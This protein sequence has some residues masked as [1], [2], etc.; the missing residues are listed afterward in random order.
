MKNFTTNASNRFCIAVVILSAAVC[1]AGAAV[2]GSETFK[3]K[4]AGCHG[5]DGGGKTALGTKLKLRDLRSADVQ[6]QSDSELQSVIEKGKA[7]MPAFGKTLG[8]PAVQ[9]LVAYMRTIAAK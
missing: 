4:C 1:S 5:A 8:A 9:E 7:P 2:A 6:K 3:A